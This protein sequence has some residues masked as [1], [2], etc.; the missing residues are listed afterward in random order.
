MAKTMTVLIDCAEIEAIAAYIVE[1]TKDWPSAKL[2]ELQD[3]FRR[4][5][6]D[7]D[8]VECQIEDGVAL[9]QATPVLLDALRER[10]LGVVAVV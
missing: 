2:D 5:N 3:M 7:G 8:L 9:V 6:R 1:A 10:G 4:L